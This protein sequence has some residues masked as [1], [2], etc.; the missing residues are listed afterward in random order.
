[1]KFIV[2]KRNIV[3]TMNKFMI[4]WYKKSISNFQPYEIE[5]LF[6]KIEIKSKQLITINLHQ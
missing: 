4:Q 3:P 2:F 6:R 5:Q 1:M